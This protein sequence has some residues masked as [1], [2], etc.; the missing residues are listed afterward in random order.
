MSFAW[1]EGQTEFRAL[2][3]DFTASPE[4]T[5][6]IS[7]F[8]GDE[9]VFALVLHFLSPYYNQVVP[10]K[11]R[12]VRINEMFRAT[13]NRL[14]KRLFDFSSKPGK[15]SE[16][17]WEGQT[18]PEIEIV[19]GFSMCLP[20][21]VALRWFIMHDLDKIF[22]QK[23]AEIKSLY[24]EHKARKKEFYST[25]HKKK[26][27]ERRDLMIKK[28]ISMRKPEKTSKKKN[29]TLLNRAERKLIFAGL[30]EERNL[31]RKLRK[32]RRKSFGG[33][34]GRT[35]C[36]RSLQLP[37]TDTVCAVLMKDS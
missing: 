2:L 27:K 24:D 18:N 15:R 32:E 37:S 28:V 16:L 36:N 33:R 34:A 19:P 10:W 1:K 25:N 11:G 14:K 9:E 23:E 8:K 5:E 22:W 3:K 4:N 35:N 31:E 26:K 29:K 17:V 21:A 20:R 7:R 13:M 6:R 30:Q 12:N